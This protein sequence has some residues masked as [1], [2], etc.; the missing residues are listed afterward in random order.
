[1]HIVSK[2]QAISWD[3]VNVATQSSIS[4]MRLIKTIEDGFPNTKQDLPLDI[5]EY[6]PYRKDLHYTDGVILYRVSVKKVPLLI[7]K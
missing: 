2:L 7:E 6:H 5:Q 1:M 3:M 4:M